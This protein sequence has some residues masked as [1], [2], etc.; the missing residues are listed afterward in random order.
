M[1]KKPLHLVIKALVNQYGAEIVGDHRLKGLLA[2]TLGESF[3][4]AA[5]VDQAY[6]H[7]VGLDQNN[8]PVYQWFPPVPWDCE[9]FMNRTTSL[10]NEDAVEKFRY[11]YDGSGNFP[12]AALCCSDG[13]ED[14]YGDYEYSP[15][16][17]HD[18]YTKLVNQLHID[19]VNVTLENLHQFLPELSSCRS[20]DDMS[21]AGV[22]N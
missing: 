4:N 8:E 9:C 22:V 11:V 14:S 21:L 12:A 19:G 5:S 2:D 13:V 1:P 17:L 7:Q 20:H 10:C 3:D 16:A 6:R 18:F 15:Q